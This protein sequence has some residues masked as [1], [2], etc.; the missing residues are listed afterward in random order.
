MVGR[1]ISLVSGFAF[2]HPESKTGTVPPKRAKPA[3]LMLVRRAEGWRA[4]PGCYHLV[5]LVLVVVPGATLQVPFRAPDRLMPLA[6][7]EAEGFI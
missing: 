7:L 1:L 5:D 4:H 3:A 2:D 6:E